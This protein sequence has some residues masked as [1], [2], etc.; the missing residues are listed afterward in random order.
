MWNTGKN[1][2]AKAGV[3]TTGG[4]VIHVKTDMERRA[5]VIAVPYGIAVCV[6]Q[7]E[8]VVMLPESGVCMDAVNDA[9]G[10]E[11]GE[12][13]LFS[14]GGAEIYLKADGSVVINGQMFPKAEVDQLDGD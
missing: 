4:G 2:Q 10:L 5:P 3:V 1:T 11:P 9:E 7:G 8:K 12:V 13:R 6:P 14:V